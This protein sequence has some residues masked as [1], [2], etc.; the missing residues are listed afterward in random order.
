MENDVGVQGRVTRADS[1][2][3]NDVVLA[4]ICASLLWKKGEVNHESGSPI[5][6]VGIYC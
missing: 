1:Y 6:D 3:I 2:Q 5:I 4:Q